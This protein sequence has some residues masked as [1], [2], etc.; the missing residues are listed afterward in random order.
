MPAP[1]LVIFDCDGVLIDSEMLAAK[2]HAD[3]LAALGCP[4]TLDDLVARFTGMPDRAMYE[5]ITREWGRALPPGHDEAVKA[6]IA[7]AYRRDLRPI[8]GIREA[9]AAIGGPVCVAS[10]SMPE[11]LALGL[12]LVGLHDRFAPHIFSAAQVKRG[13]PA[14]DLFLF[15]AAAMDFAPSDCLVI[16]DSLA[17]VQAARAAGMRVVGF[18]GGS[19]CG[20][21]HAERLLSQGADI[22]LSQMRDLPDAILRLAGEPAPASAAMAET[23]QP[24]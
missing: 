23:R 10:S 5:V 21:G 20:P 9:L 12:T 6:T 8:A 1:K 3:A 4:L 24:R 18:A 19:H 17:G 11:K 14:P 22:V 2:A 16:E 13:K 7:E 15:A